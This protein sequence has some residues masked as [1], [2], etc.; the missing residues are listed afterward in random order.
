LKFDQKTI[1]EACGKSSFSRGQEYFKSGRVLSL[2]YDA[3]KRGVE[4][5]GRTLGSGGNIYNQKV[6]LDFQGGYIEIDGECDCPVTYNCKHVAA[7]CLEYMGEIEAPSLRPIPVVIPEIL[8]Q[9]KV[10]RWLQNLTESATDYRSPMAQKTQDWLVFIL[11][12]QH[13]SQS[14][15][16]PRELSVSIRATHQ[17]KNGK[18][19]IKGREIALHNIDDRHCDFHALPIDSDITAFLQTTTEYNY[20]N[21]P[22]TI[23]GR[24]GASALTLM[25][26]SG[27]CYWQNSDSSPIQNGEQRQLQLGWEAQENGDLALQHN[28]GKHCLLLNTHPVMYLDI[29]LSQ[30]GRLDVQQWSQKQLIQLAQAPQIRADEADT[31]TQQLLQSYPKL[32]LP[33]PA[34]IAIRH[35]EGNEMNPSLT[36]TSVAHMGQTLEHCL[37]LDF[38]YNGDRVPAFP[39]SEQSTFSSQG[40]W[41][42]LT[43]NISA[44][45]RAI[46]TLIGYGFKLCDPIGKGLQPLKLLPMSD[47]TNIANGGCWADFIE[48]GVDALRDENWQIEID[49]QFHLSFEAANWEAEIDGDDQENDND[50]FSLR[51]DLKIGDESLP[52]APLLTPLL[53]LDPAELPEVITLP[54]GQHRYIRLPYERIQPFLSTLQELF[55]RLPDNNGQLRISRFDAISIDQL[56]E[57]GAAIRGAENLRQLAKKMQNFDGIKAVELPVGLNAELRPYQQSG[58]NW[59]QFLR[60]YRFAGI[61]ADDM[62]LGKTVQTLAHLLVEK[63][64]G[65]LDKPAL[66]V[67]PTSLM[68]NW[69]REAERFTPELRVIVLHGTDRHQFFDEITNCDLLLTTYPLLSRDSEQLQAQHYHS[70]VLDEAQAIKNP[71]TKMA[72]LVRQLRSEHRLCLTG[73][74]MENHLGELWSLFDF[75]MPG[76]LGDSNTFKKQYRTPIEVHGDIEKQ[77][78][79]AQRVLPFLLRREKDE[80]ASELPPKTEILQTVE[81][82]GK[83]AELYESIRLAM[84]KRVREAI[85]TQGLARSHI[86]ILDALLKLRQVCCDPRLLKLD[87]AKK[88]TQSAKLSLLMDLLPEQIEEGRR[89]IL[90]SQFTSMLTLIEE[91]LKKYNIEYTKLTGQTIKRDEAIQRFR[92]G[93]VNLFLISLKAGGTGLNLTEADTVILY[94][95]WWNPAVEAQAIDRAHRIGQDKPVFIYRLM[96]SGSVEEKMLAMQDKKRSLAKGIYSAKGKGETPLLDTH[97]LQNLFSP[98]GHL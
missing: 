96:V 53:G 86:T 34:E 71:N 67:A 61:L 20:W 63:N 25:L 82:E 70:I 39:F 13:D 46:N 98:L 66:V 11:G 18:G 19:L 52:L 55:T 56:A 93:H 40:D 15:L 5:I 58:L 60:E 90:F 57:Q 22:A 16:K 9:G 42:R 37:L 68:G 76:F 27:R 87:Q 1:I 65:R 54:I 78:K 43:R 33:L 77:Q 73:T 28:L 81:L 85:K 35:N 62:G 6:F 12:I 51:F 94:D 4:L 80:V 23:R 41:V 92:E 74:P 45:E 24:A 95:P 50:W 26:E 72:K 10:S 91:E 44:E 48:Q 59:L 29:N 64:A 7:A 17:R 2:D 83:Q 38:D 89:I 75:L 21:S 31:V 79:L 97:T 3:I 32:S 84:D 8:E 49:E 88:V 36:L 14:L 47:I 69:R 30:A